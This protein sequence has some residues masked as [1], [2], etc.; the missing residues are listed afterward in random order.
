MADMDSDATASETG[1]PEPADSPAAP[2][3]G[4]GRVTIGMFILALLLLTG[5]AIASYLSV[6]A[7]T[8]QSRWVDH[9][10]QVIRVADRLL[11]DHQDMSIG[12]RGYLLTGEQQYFDQY[13]LGRDHIG[14]DIG[15]L[16]T[17]TADNPTQQARIA[18]LQ[19]LS[20]QFRQHLV[21]SIGEKRPA[22]GQITAALAA[23]FAS[24]RQIMAQLRTIIGAM[25][26]EEDVLLAE[27]SA[28][29]Q[30]GRERVLQIIVAG[31]ALSLGALVLCLLLLNRQIYTR[32]AAESHVVTLNRALSTR[33][34]Q[35]ELANRELEGFSYSISHDLRSP[36]RAIDL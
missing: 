22:T 29:A 26:Q 36:L 16:E 7:S 17:L 31:N 24:S 10:Y 27:R 2:L 9:T 13:R 11:L 32:R 35:L 25:V 23:E 8:D 34:A 20:L 1:L 18:S 5:I 21:E 3:T 6:I 19:T 28:E 4:A 30:Q 14:P 12:Q 15:V 33:A